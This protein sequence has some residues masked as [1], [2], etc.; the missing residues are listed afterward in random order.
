MRQKVEKLKQD[1]KVIL[2]KIH[3]IEDEIEKEAK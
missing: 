1:A 3:L 2:E